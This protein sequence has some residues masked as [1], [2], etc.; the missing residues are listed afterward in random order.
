MYAH[1]KSSAV[2]HEVRSVHFGGIVDVWC[3]WST[4]G[5]RFSQEPRSKS[6]ICRDC[7]DAR[8]KHIKETT[9][10]KLRAPIDF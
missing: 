7:I 8:K 2:D 9:M 1:V 5:L 3:G 6:R 10:A 4:A